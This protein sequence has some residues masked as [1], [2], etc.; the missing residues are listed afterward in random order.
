MIKQLG[1]TYSVNLFLPDGFEARSGQYPISYSYQGK[2]D[3]LGASLTAA[4]KTYSR[5]SEGQAEFS[6]DGDRVR[7]VFS[8]SVANK[9]A[10]AVDRQMVTVEGQ[11]VFE[12]AALSTL[13]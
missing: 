5:D 10:G 12:R 11:A 3:T 6:D 13:Y 4:G 7:I 8:F 2:P 9:K 1:K